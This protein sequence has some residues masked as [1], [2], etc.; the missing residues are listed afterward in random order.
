MA[1]NL[2]GV[3]GSAV[4]TGI[5]RESFSIKNKAYRLKTNHHENTQHNDS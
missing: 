4:A 1:P 5:N 3:N 2:T